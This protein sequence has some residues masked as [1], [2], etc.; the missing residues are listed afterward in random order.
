MWIPCLQKNVE[1]SKKCL[2][3]SAIFL[4]CLPKAS[5]SISIYVDTYVLTMLPGSLSSQPAYVIMCQS[6]FF[7]LNHQLQY[8]YAV[9]LRRASQCSMLYVCCRP[10]GFL[11]SCTQW[12]SVAEVKWV[13]LLNRLPRPSSRASQP[14]WT[15][16]CG[17]FIATRSTIEY[18]VLNGHFIRVHLA[19][20]RLGPP[21]A[22]RMA[23]ILGDKDSISLWKLPERFWGWFWMPKFK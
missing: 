13:W 10:L 1:I 19:A 16:P 2:F 4:L 15:I 23:I 20:T 9:F 11:E 21:F 12:P 22:F 8:V 3:F 18:C 5:I 17:K 14:R 6:H 7:P